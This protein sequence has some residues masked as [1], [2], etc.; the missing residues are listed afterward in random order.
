MKTLDQQNK[1]DTHGVKDIKETHRFKEPNWHLRIAFV[2]NIS[3][4]VIEL[5][6]MLLFDLLNTSFS[7]WVDI[8][9]AFFL[10]ILIFPLIY[11]MGIRQTNSQIA[12]R[13][14]AEKAVR[15]SE[16]KYHYM[17][18]N[19]PQSMWVYD[20]ETLAF[21]E[22]ND[23]A[24]NHYGYSREEFLSMTIKDIGPIEDIPALLKDVELD[25]QRFNVAG[26]WRHLKKKRR[27]N[28]CRDN[29]TYNS[30]K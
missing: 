25:N 28:I 30:I 24:I 14:L 20:L 19:N 13:K 26:K 29:I 10:P 5:L 27:N 9:D 18:A 21:L 2:A 11:Y 15:Q 16:E 7:L 23:A 12:E 1:Q 3:I 8:I 4:I 6:I 17:F 22:V